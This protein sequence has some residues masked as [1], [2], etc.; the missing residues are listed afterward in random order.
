MPFLFILFPF[1]RN[2]LNDTH[3]LLPTGLKRVGVRIKNRQFKTA[4]FQFQVVDYQATTFHV[5]DFH[6]GTLPVD[7]D[8][9]VAVLYVVS[10]LVGHHPAQGVKAPPHICRVSIQ[11]IPHRG[12]KAEHRYR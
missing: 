12:G 5:Q 9:N 6:A 10:H 11:V 7:E 3:Q 2:T 4:L 8:V 1:H